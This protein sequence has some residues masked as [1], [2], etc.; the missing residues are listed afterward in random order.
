MI[1]LWVTLLLLHRVYSLIP[2]VTVELGEPVTLTCSVDYKNQDVILQWLKQTVIQTLGVSQR[3]SLTEAALGENVTLSCKVLEVKPGL[4][5]WFKMGFGHVVQTIV[6]GSF[7]KLVLQ[8]QFNNSRFNVTRVGNTY[9][10][11]IQNVR[12]EDEATYLCQAG[13]AYTMKFFNET[14][15]AVNDPN[16]KLKALYVKQYPEREQVPPGSTATLQCSLLSGNEEPDGC[17]GERRMFWYRSGSEQDPGVIYTGNFSCDDQERRSCVSHLS[18]PIQNHSD[19]GTYYCAV[20][21]CGKILFG[22]G[23]TLETKQEFPLIIVL[24]TLLAFMSLLSIALILTK[25]MQKQVCEH[26]K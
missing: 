16:K 15:V 3:I 20:V 19:T 23:T 13:T 5:Y 18:K 12:K 8:G 11:T 22:K 9:F 14:H 10:L 6:L 17:P 21:A 26:C 4:F 24:G 7:D 25:I 2:A 1:L